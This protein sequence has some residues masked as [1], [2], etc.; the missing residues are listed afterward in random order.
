MRRILSIDGGGIRGVFALQV[1]AR[2]EALLR[3]EHGRADLVLA[4]A[5]DLFAGTSTGAII[6]ACLC[7]GMPV[8]EVHRLYV[9]RGRDMFA[10]E[11]WY[12]W[13]YAKYRSGAIAAMFKSLFAETDGMPALLGTSR[14]RKT[15]LVVMRNA[16][17]G[18]P[19]PISNN[20]HATFNDRCRPD[21]N[22][23]IPLWQLIR[24]STAAPS[25]FPPQ[26][27]DVGGHPFV[28]VDGGITPFNNPALLAVVMATLPQFRMN[29][30]ASR[31]QLHVVSVGTGLVRV[32][33]PRKRPVS[34]NILDHLRHVIPAL[35]ASTAL[36]QDMLCR[37]L[38][39]C[40]HGDPID[41]ELGELTAPT[42]LSAD[43]QKFTYVRYDMPL[44][45]PQDAPEAMPS[46]DDLQ[47]LQWLIDQGRACAADEVRREHLFP[48]G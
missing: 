44:Q 29:W 11:P 46:L 26:P 15:L 34:I 28:F 30:P 31:E 48:R 35:L 5:F 10:R 19:W 2:V 45:S 1:L 20:P 6:A 32:R 16:T 8:E 25:Y 23:D 4:D 17:T 14:L 21:C 13:W 9:D 38:G 36:E 3:Q 24:G 18:S 33:L 47:R 42:L 40:L 43:Q 39:D 22:L 37:I 12:R 7:W 27:I 41:S